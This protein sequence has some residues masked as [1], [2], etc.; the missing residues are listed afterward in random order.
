VQLIGLEQMLQLQITLGVL[1]YSS[2][3]VQQHLQCYQ[4]KKQLAAKLN[5]ANGAEPSAVSNTIAA[6]DA[7]LA[8]NNA[9]NWNRLTPQQRAFVNQLQTILDNYNNGFIGPGHCS[10]NSVLFD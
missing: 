3:Q 10:E 4:H 7:F 8:Q 6:A 9:S 2:D 1:G 5:I